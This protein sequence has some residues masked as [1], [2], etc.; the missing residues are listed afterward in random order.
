[1]IGIFIFFSL[2]AH[3]LIRQLRSNA[4]LSV[5]LHKNLTEKRLYD[6]QAQ[7]SYKEFVMRRP[8]GK[9]AIKFVSK[10]E[11]AEIVK[12]STGENFIAFLGE[13]PLYDSY[14][15]RI[16]EEYYTPELLAQIAAD[17]QRIE[18]VLEVQYPENHTEEIKA[19]IRKAG[20]VL[21]SFA[22]L[23]IAIVC[24]LINNSIKLAVYSQR[25]V[26]RSMQ[27]VGA[28]P[29][30]IKKPF[31]I[32]A[33]IQGIIGGAISVFILMLIL[34]V[35]HQIITQ[36]SALDVT[37]YAVLIACF[38]VF[39]GGIICFLSAYASVSRYIKMRLDDLHKR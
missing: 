3:L 30:F 34:L 26:I 11:A 15:V 22:L 38:L 36:L 27:L 8:D 31:L 7:L 5:Y 32:S 9:P 35:A 6:L 19:N 21:G 1:M 18:G 28:T 12:S 29:F 20:V 25:F 33:T 2:Y 13:N 14:V 4:E 16:K 39:L 37:F 24:I 17:V 23:L 10:E